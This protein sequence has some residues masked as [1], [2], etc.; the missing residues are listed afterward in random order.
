M[1]KAC[2]GIYDRE[3]NY[4]KRLGSYIRRKGGDI[5]EVRIFTKLETL[6]R[7][8]DSDGLTMALVSVDAKELCLAHDGVWTAVLSEERQKETL[9]PFNTPI[10]K[11]IRETG[12]GE[13]PCRIVKCPLIE[14][15]QSAE[16]IWKA[17]LAL[18]GERIYGNGQKKTDMRNFQV[19]AVA[20]PVHRIGKTSL[21]YAMGRV[22][23][24]KREGRVLVL[25]L[26]EF[27]F[28]KSAEPGTADSEGDISELFYYYSQGQLNAEKILQAIGKYGEADVIAPAKM[29][30]DLYRDGKPYPAA[31]FEALTM[32]GG[33]Q[34]LILDIG[35]ALAFHTE[36]LGIC[37]QIVIP[38]YGRQEEVRIVMF[39]EWLKRAGIQGKQLLLP[40]EYREKEL[41][42]L[43]EDVLLRCR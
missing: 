12:P 22:L 15:Y 5:L 9:Y 10:P 3:S 33:Y 2:L 21:A 1:G 43:A 32:I 40:V 24:G 34:Y 42:H 29:P 17:L 13:E 23:A 8:L 35:N 25:S 41:D 27:S 14:K 19:L 39:Q 18:A 7:C 26:D 31:F 16:E 20:S 6:K 30:E 28:G 38:T 36:I 37:S 11:L 4:A